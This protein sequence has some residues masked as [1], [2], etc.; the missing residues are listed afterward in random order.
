[1]KIETLRDGAFKI[2]MTDTDMHRWGL[3][4]EDMSADDAPT[5]AAVMRLLHIARQRDV[6]PE[7]VGI[8]VE[9]VPVADGCV[10]LFTPRRKRPCFRMPHAKVYALAG[11]NDVLQLGA[12]LSSAVELPTASL[13]GF[14]EEYRLIVYPGLC[15]WQDTCRRISEFGRLAGEGSAVA[16]FVEEH[17]NAIAVGDALNRLRESRL[18]ERRRPAR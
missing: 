7:A 10:L 1:M 8:M 11:A 15:A 4:F 5:R 6:F 13:Y 16:A 2:W 17:G 18:P 9:A 14:G 3:R 12:G